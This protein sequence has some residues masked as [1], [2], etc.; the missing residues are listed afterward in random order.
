MGIER[1]AAEDLRRARAR[2]QDWIRGPALGAGERVLAR[3]ERAEHGY[4]A[5]VI[6]RLG[7]SVHR[8]LGVL[9]VRPE[10]L[11]IAPIDRKS[12]TD[13]AVESRDRGGAEHNELVLAEPLAGRASGFPRAKVIERLGSMNAP[14]T[15]SLIAIHAH[16]I[17]TEFPKEVI[18]EATA[19][20][21][22]DPRTRT[23]CAPF[24]SSPSIPRMRAITTTRCGRGRTAIRRTPAD[25]S[26]S[27]PSPMS[28]TM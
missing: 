8:V 13:F 28:R 3:L 18:D 7:A 24:R 5:R 6:K 4:E 21:P 1:G 15:V 11:R 9:H 16:G 27:S 19:A 12:R 17:P 25:I 20:T 22:P 2:R 10:G 14:R 26:R 23:T